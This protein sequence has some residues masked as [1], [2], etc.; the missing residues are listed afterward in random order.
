MKQQVLKFTLIELLV[1]IAIIAILAAML[2]PALNNARSRAQA[3]RCMNNLKQIGIGCIQYAGDS[4]GFIPAA[5]DNTRTVTSTGKYAYYWTGALVI[6]GY[7]PETN[8]FQC[9]T[10][11]NNPE[12]Y[13]A[14]TSL[15]GY[16]TYGIA[17]DMSGTIRDESKKIYNNLDKLTRGKSPSICFMAGDSAKLV[18]GQ[19]YPT[20]MISWGNGCVN[21]ASLRHANNANLVFA[22]GSARSVSRNEAYKISVFPGLEQVIMADL[23]KASNI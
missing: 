18:N 11:P 4:S 14:N 10:A 17:Y 8:I 16:R 22:D 5:Y 9:P 2:L 19:A 1:V 6:G 7:L 12:K 23:F 20:H 3:T 21:L 13:I 15:S